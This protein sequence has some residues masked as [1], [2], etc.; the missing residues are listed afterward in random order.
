M[1]KHTRLAAALQQETAEAGI[2]QAQ[3]AKQS[4]LTQGAISQLIGYGYRAAPATLKRLVTGWQNPHSGKR[5]LAAHVMD[6]IHRSGLN[7]NDYELLAKG[8]TLEKIPT[9]FETDLLFLQETAEQVPVLRDLI[10]DLAR[11][12][13]E[14]M[15]LAQSQA[16]AAA[17][18]K[19]AYST[20]KR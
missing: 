13:R 7:P 5:I 8:L 3:L 9:P 18:N 6:E 16:L 1:R 11:L 2:T 17:D 12:T 4:G 15:H 19:A 10:Q 14:E 20:K